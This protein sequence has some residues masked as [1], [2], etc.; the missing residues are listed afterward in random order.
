[1]TVW[2]SKPVAMIVFGDQVGTCLLGVFK[3]NRVNGK[4]E[5]LY[6]KYRA[7]KR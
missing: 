2:S 5:A 7:Q 1:M 4:E 6:I 3:E